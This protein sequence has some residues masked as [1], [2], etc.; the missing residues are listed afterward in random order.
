MRKNCASVSLASGGGGSYV[1]FAQ[2]WDAVLG[3]QTLPPLAP[4][5][6]SLR[7]GQAKEGNEEQCG[8]E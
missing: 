4:P 7:S 2:I 1:R 8:V 6:P 3:L 5:Y